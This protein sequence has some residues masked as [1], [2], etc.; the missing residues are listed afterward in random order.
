MKTYG[1]FKC[2]ACGQRAHAVWHG[3]QRCMAICATCATDVLPSLA[4]DA[5]H[6]GL[7]PSAPQ[8][9]HERMSARF[10]RALALRLQKEHCER[11]APVNGHGVHDPCPELPF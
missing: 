4:A 8:W 7:S 9:A 10:W 11:R 5:V 2:D 6:L 3:A 1:D